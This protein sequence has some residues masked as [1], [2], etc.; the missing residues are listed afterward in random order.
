M[1]VAAALPAVGGTTSDPKANELQSDVKLFNRWS[2][3][4]VQV[5]SSQSLAYYPFLFPHF[6]VLLE[7]MAQAMRVQVYLR[8]TPK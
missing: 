4:E 8:L 2:F 1:E 6:I 5:L 7:V 3:D